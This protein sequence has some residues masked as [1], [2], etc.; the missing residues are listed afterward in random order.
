VVILSLVVVLGQQNFAARL[1]NLRERIQQIR[2]S[3]DVQLGKT[4]DG[5]DAMGIRSQ[6]NQQFAAIATF[7]TKLETEAKSLDDK[8]EAAII[9]I[10]AAYAGQSPTEGLEKLANVIA[11]KY[12]ESSRLCGAIEQLT[13]LETTS[14]KAYVTIEKTLTAA[15]N[16]EV[17]VSTALANVFI[18]DAMNGTNS[19]EELAKFEKIAK[20]FPATKAGRRAAF[21]VDIRQKLVAFGKM[22]DLQFELV[23]GKK[24][25]LS[26]LKGKVVMLDFWGF[27]SEESGEDIEDMKVIAR[28]V[29]ND[30]VVIGINTDRY[31]RADLLD[32]L[33]EFK[34]EFPNY[35]VGSPFAAMP[36]DFGVKQYPSK[37]IID[38]EGKV[39]F[40]PGQADWRSKL[41]ELLTKK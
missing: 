11:T 31:R 14:P 41:E 25:T 13:F 9:R 4:L 35:A 36:M 32:R 15:K 6:S 24:I 12:R 37:V 34:I 20:F 22:S 1:S 3:E 2:Y 23:S 18:Q 28:Q 10:E 19:P 30:L 7:A 29:P 8:A 26:S 17:V 21:V 33:N 40:A 5:K 27:W 38:R 39:A 16:P